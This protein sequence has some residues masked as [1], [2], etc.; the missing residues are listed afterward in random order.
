MTAKSIGPL[1]YSITG[2]AFALLL[3][4]ALSLSVAACGKAAQTDVNQNMVSDSSAH[5]AIQ[6]IEI[7]VKDASQEPEIVERNE[8]GLVIPT[9]T[10]KSLI[11]GASQDEYNIEATDTLESN[12]FHS[13]V[14]ARVEPPLSIT[15]VGRE[16]DN[17]EGVASTYRPFVEIRFKV[18]EYLK[19]NGTDEIAVDYPVH[20]HT[21][22]EQEKAEEI[23]LFAMVERNTNW[24]H[25]EGVV[26]LFHS[27]EFEREPAAAIRTDFNYLFASRRALLAG[28][29]HGLPHTFDSHI[30]VWLPA[31]TER[32]LNNPPDSAQ[33]F[34]VDPK[35]IKGL[36]EPVPMTVAQLRNEIKAVDELVAAGEGIDGYKECLRHTFG[37]DT[38]KLKFHELHDEPYVPGNI[39]SEIRSGSPIGTVIRSPGAAGAGY[40]KHWT[41]GEHANLF[42]YVIADHDNNVKD[43]DFEATRTDLVDYRTLFRNTRPLP[44]GVYKVEVPAQAAVL[45]PCNA[46]PEPPYAT[47]TVTVIAPDD[48][49]HEAFFDPEDVGSEA[50]GEGDGNGLFDPDVFTAPDGAETILN[51]IDWSSGNVEMQLTPHNPLPDH[52]IDFIA[53]DGTVS[54]RLDFDDAVEIADDGVSELSWGVCDQPW[55]DG[56]KLMIRISESG[57]DLTGTTSDS[58][59]AATAA[60]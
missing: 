33:Q 13:S 37:I 24:D 6:E 57:A 7:P 25:L 39:D 46:I 51:R 1:R 36:T 8:N 29:P 19:G 38:F 18:I 58:D 53:L 14:I 34:L 10:P 55:Q 2:L 30:K 50:F 60:P 12:I 11:Q 45:I 27:S 42:E 9:P 3:V 31:A 22:L 23:A 32:A 44:R 49:I 28:E 26:F 17:G 40:I 52:H 48:A 20:R 47:A 43:I 5:S 35:P 56:D 15:P 21:Y 54:L 59:C 4:V 16:I 41:V